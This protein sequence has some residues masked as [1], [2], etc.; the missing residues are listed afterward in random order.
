MFINYN[1]LN[2]H[3]SIYNLINPFLPIPDEHFIFSLPRHKEE[4][5]SESRVC[6]F[7]RTTGSVDIR[8]SSCK[9]GYHHRPRS[10][11][12]TKARTYTD[13]R[14]YS[15]VYYTR[16]SFSFLC[17][18]RF[19]GAR[20]TMSVYSCVRQ[21]RHNARGAHIAVRLENWYLKPPLKLRQILLEK[22][23]SRYSLMFIQCLFE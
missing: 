8:P 22:T 19:A 7:E 21:S 20:L 17:L 6:L 18:V 12:R 1:F 13:T 3:V 4:S 10:S 9:R 5:W 23:D 15:R 14:I 16:R 2:L 11:S